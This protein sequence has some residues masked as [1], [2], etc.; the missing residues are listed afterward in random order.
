MSHC[1]RKSFERAAGWGSH[2]VRRLAALCGSVHP[3]GH[4]AR[5]HDGSPLY[6][7]DNGCERGPFWL[8]ALCL[9]RLELD[10]Y[11]QVTNS[12]DRRSTCKVASTADDWQLLT[13][14]LQ[15]L[16]IAF[17]KHRVVRVEAVLLTK[18]DRIT[19]Q[20]A[21]ALT[22][23]RDAHQ[24]NTHSIWQRSLAEL[25]QNGRRERNGRLTLTVTANARTAFSLLGQCSAIKS[26]RAICSPP[27]RAAQ[28]GWAEMHMARGGHRN[29]VADASARRS[30]RHAVST[31]CRQAICARPVNCL[32]L[33]SDA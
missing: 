9:G 27:L 11:L 32:L 33:C 15:V 17:G 12:A 19:L 14:K 29:C 28:P 8:A 30:Q 2:R 25:D 10:C 24:T 16:N 23:P 31:T 22:N 21:C 4:D 6:S 20:S 26:F 1:L 13:N 5:R 7:L 18:S 3:A